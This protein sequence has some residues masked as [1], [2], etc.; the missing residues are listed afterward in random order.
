MNSAYNFFFL[1]F[2]RKR[3]LGKPWHRQVMLKFMW[4]E[5]IYLRIGCSG[6]FI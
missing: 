3:P 4:T 5:F 1:K 2:G 6:E